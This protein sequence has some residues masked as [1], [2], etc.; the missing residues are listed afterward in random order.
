VNARTPRVG[1]FDLA[2]VERAE[3][4]AYQQSAVYRRMQAL[5]RSAQLAEAAG[6][7]TPHRRRAGKLCLI[8]YQLRG[9]SYLC[10]GVRYSG[11]EKQ[12][13]CLT[14]IAAR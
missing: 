2:A 13:C 1:L 6:L 14:P 12:G 3:Q 10:A 11:G 9:P 4:A 5:R 8:W 7:D